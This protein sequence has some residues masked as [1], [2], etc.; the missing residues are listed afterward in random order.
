MN[1][2]ALFRSW[3]ERLT[4]AES[5]PWAAAGKALLKDSFGYLVGA[6]LLG[7]GSVVLVP[8]YTRCLQPAE[9]GAYSIL[10]ITLAIVVSAATLKLDVA[11][12]KWYA[13]TPPQKQSSLFGTVLAASLAAGVVGGTLLSLSTGS[14]WVSHGLG[15]G[16]QRIGWVLFCLVV[17]ENG[18][19]L[20]LTR[21]RAERRVLLFSGCMFLRLV[22]IVA[23]SCFF[24]LRARL[25]VE[26]IFLGRLCGDL[27]AT[28]VLA[29]LL[30]P[31]ARIGF[32][33]AR[34]RPMLRFATPLLWSTFA[35][36]LL[37]ASGR[38]WLTRFCSLRE[39][40]LY[41]AAIKVSSVSQIFLTQPFGAAWGGLLFQIAKWP[42]ARL[43]YSKILTYSFVASL[44]VALLLTGCA[45][46]LLSLF[47]N[48]AYHDA[49]SVLPL[50]FLARALAILEFPASVGIYLSGQTLW[51]PA[52]YTAGLLVAL[53]S[54]WLLV[55]R[56]G[57]AGSA[58]SWI[59]AWI[60]IGGSMLAISHR[61]YPLSYNWRLMALPV[62]SWLLL[63]VSRTQ[64]S[65]L[66]RALPLPY[67]A[68]TSLAGGCF[69]FWLTLPRMA[70]RRVR[71][72]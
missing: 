41:G 42:D 22:V 46:L 4:G 53:G 38:L 26:G 29:L 49:L 55:P 64:V 5:A 56:F 57:M 63:L 50:V 15:L 6:A 28:A 3:R 30:L 59:L 9:F 17:A 33:W 27:V 35:A 60:C 24:L 40:G 47:T 39:V 58:W 72:G 43:I 1:A 44:T 68:M 69:A 2:M 18:Q 37:D 51:F 19:A 25:G 8:L 65:F 32:D 34:V 16:N 11:Y 62:V 67:L 10:E 36:M 13:E 21:L 20:L 52:T 23:A 14:A 54:G 61:Y 12:L 48:R 45:P 66:P 70:E 71:N 7:F 31:G